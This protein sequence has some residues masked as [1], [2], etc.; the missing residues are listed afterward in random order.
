M[1]RVKKNATFAPTRMRHFSFR[2]DSKG[3]QGDP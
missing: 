2:G 1:N 3:P